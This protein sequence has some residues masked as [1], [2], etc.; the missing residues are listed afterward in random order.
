MLIFR[1]PEAHQD[2]LRFHFFLA[3]IV[4]SPSV[5]I[6]SA[7]IKIREKKGHLMHP[8]ARSREK[9]AQLEKD[10]KVL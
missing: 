6:E 10:H 1:Q 7:A 2:D 5:T 8:N 3:Y 4:F 9:F